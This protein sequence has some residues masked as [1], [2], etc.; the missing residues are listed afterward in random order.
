M[1]DNPK[2]FLVNNLICL[3]L[4]RLARL[5]STEAATFSMKQAVSR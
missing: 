3:N 4:T 5:L 2:K 1:S